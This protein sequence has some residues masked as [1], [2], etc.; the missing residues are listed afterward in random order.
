VAFAKFFI[1]TLDWGY[2]TTS[3]TYVRHYYEAT[4]FECESD[5][6]GVDEA[7]QKQH[8]F[9]GDRFLNITVRQI[10]STGKHEGTADLAVKA[11]FD[12]T[13]TDVVDAAGKSVQAVPPRPGY[14]E[15]L[16]LSW[17]GAGWSVVDMIPAGTPE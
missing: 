9:V 7:E 5:A 8:R 17:R 2:A 4:C 15:T 11:V 6:Q 16:Y 12:I 1:Q 14:S 3:S 13:G 10:P